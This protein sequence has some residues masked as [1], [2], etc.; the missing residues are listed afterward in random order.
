MSETST[1][2]ICPALVPIVHFDLTNSMGIPAQFEHPTYLDAIK[3]VVAACNA[4]G[5][6]AGIMSGSVADAQ[7]SLSQGFR[8]IAYSGDLWLYQQALREG[9]TAIRSHAG[10]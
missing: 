10:Q 1:A 4:H 2:S 8:A 3:R 6:A 7:L 5:K 9:L